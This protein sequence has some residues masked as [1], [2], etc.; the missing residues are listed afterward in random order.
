MYRAM[1]SEDLGNYRKNI[2]ENLGCGMAYLGE[3]KDKLVL[4]QTRNKEL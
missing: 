1:I 4:E 3:R 2:L